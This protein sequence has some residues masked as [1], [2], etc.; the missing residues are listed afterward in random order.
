MLNFVL[1]IC[2]VCLQ[3]FDRNKQM[4]EAS[5]ASAQGKPVIQ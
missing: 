4:D 2:F 5:A 3:M 1:F